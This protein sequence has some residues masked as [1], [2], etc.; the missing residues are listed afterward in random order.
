MFYS[1][2]DL[3]FAIFSHS[4][5]YILLALYSLFTVGIEWLIDF[6]SKEAVEPKHVGIIDG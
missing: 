6:L 2:Y 4:T 5:F 3:C 1:A